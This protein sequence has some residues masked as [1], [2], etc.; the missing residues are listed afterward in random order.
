MGRLTATVK[1]DDPGAVVNRLAKKLA[2][3]TEPHNTAK[4][5]QGELA[6]SPDW[7]LMIINQSYTPTNQDAKYII[8]RNKPPNTFRFKTK[9]AKIN[10]SKIYGPRDS[11]KFLAAV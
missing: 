4:I 9:S 10:P 8:P 7:L 5:N 2:A 6:L 1:K 11:R 3:A